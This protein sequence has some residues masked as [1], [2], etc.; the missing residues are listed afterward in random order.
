MHQKQGAEQW[1]K[2]REKDQPREDVHEQL[3]KENFPD[4]AAD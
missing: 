1:R 3:T 2:S 4:M